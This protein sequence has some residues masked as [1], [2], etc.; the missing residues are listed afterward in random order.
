MFTVVIS[1]PLRSWSCCTIVGNVYPHR[2]YWNF[3]QFLRKYWLSRPTTSTS[4][5]GAAAVE[6]KKNFSVSPRKFPLIRERLG[7]VT[8]TRVG[9]MMRLVLIY[10]NLI[11]IDHVMMWHYI[12]SASWCW[13]FADRISCKRSNWNRAGALLPYFKRTQCWCWCPL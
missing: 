4:T 7:R 1:C 12:Y 3:Q 10:E 9:G 5:A 11:A 13:N 8:S 2:R 6:R